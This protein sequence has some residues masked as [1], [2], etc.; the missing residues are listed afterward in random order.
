MTTTEGDRCI[1]ELYA[2]GSAARYAHV[3][4]SSMN[5]SG[6]KKMVSVTM[7][8]LNDVI[9]KCPDEPNIKRAARGIL[10]VLAFF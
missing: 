3:V 10:G 7:N 9:A 5:Q 2:G 4:K 1:N 8:L 6:A